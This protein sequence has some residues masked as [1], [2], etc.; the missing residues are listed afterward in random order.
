MTDVP[1]GAR[2][3]AGLRAGAPRADVT[4]LA[5]TPASRAQRGDPIL[6]HPD[7]ASGHRFLTDLP[8]RDLE[9]LPRCAEFPSTVAALGRWLRSPSAANVQALIRRASSTADKTSWT[10]PLAGM[11]VRGF[12]RGEGVVRSGDGRWCRRP[13]GGRPPLSGAGGPGDE[14][15]V[16][17]GDASPRPR[18]TIGQSRVWRRQPA[19][20]R[21]R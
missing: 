20:Q 7:A 17:V 1:L 3:A 10:K 5:P 13:S 6:R 4:A 11:A 14:F 21:A 19:G 2:R 18:V 12:Y 16:G 15:P 8:L 9:G